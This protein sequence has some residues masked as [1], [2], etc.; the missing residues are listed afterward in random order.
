MALADRLRLEK[1]YFPRAASAAEV[2]L[3]LWE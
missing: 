2:A 1:Y 3:F